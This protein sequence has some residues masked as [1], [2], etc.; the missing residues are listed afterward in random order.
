MPQPVLLPDA[1]SQLE[2]DDH[3]D[4]ESGS[5]QRPGGDFTHG[6]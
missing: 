5:E 4:E 3:P 6:K 1:P 2:E